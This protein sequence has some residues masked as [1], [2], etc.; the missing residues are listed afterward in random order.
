MVRNFDISDN[1]P[2]VLK[3]F[4]S[5][6][7]YVEVCSLQDKNE[8]KKLKKYDDRYHSACHNSGHNYQSLKI[9]GVPVPQYRCL[10][11]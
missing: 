7:R 4:H 8:Q 6:S 11:M 5:C 2:D 3:V 9:V 1:L 10:Y